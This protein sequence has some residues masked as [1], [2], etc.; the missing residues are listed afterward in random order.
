MHLRGEPF[1]GVLLVGEQ[2]LLLVG[3]V[4]QGRHGRQHLPQQL[5]GDMLVVV[6]VGAVDKGGSA[7]LT[8]RVLD[9]HRP[10]GRRARLRPTAGGGGGGVAGRRP[11]GS[12]SGG[13][14]L[15]FGPQ[16]RLLEDIQRRLHMGG[17]ADGE[18]H[19]TET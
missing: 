12:G 2:A 16:A 14:G 13:G 19:G 10:R 18:R 6:A 1:D 17:D 5:V 9:R 15:L 3:G 8:V 11:G 4:L 7:G